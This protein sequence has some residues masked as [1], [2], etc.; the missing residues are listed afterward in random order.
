MWFFY[1]SADRHAGMWRGP[2]IS[3]TPDP[4]L[5][6]FVHRKHLVFQLLSWIQL[7]STQ[8]CPMLAASKATLLEDPRHLTA[9]RHL[10]ALSFSEAPGSWL[11]ARC[12]DDAELGAGSL[13][14]SSVLR[15]RIVPDLGTYPRTGVG[16][17]FGLGNGSAPVPFGP[18]G[19]DVS[20]IPITVQA[21]SCWS[22]KIFKD[23]H[24]LSGTIDY[25]F[26]LVASSAETKHY[27][28]RVDTHRRWSIRHVKN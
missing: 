17:G 5:V 18:F 1:A 24:L 22:Y 21:T 25:L 14:T 28:S 20:A 13:G 2:F 16:V 12:Q 3:S 11:V 15:E 10:P 9:L 4:H 19:V 26:S 27:S 7:S 8:R 6:P 23:F